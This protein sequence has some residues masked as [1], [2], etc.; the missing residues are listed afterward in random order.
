MYRKHLTRT[1]EQVSNTTKVGE[2]K[3]KRG[4]KTKKKFEH[5]KSEK[6]NSKESWEKMM[7]A[8]MET[9]VE[10]EMKN[11]IAVLRFC[12]LS[13]WLMTPFPRIFRYFTLSIW[14]VTLLVSDDENHPVMR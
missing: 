11:K 9:R 6:A 12:F 3:K 2:K 13:H 14:T 4:E 5:F 7:S 10:K 8:Q 1:K